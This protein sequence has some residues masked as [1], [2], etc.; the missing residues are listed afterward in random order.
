MERNEKWKN[1]I[2][3]ENDRAVLKIKKQKEEESVVR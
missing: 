2:I 1:D 3:A